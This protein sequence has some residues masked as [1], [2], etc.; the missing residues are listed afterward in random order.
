MIYKKEI[1][2]RVNEIFLKSEPVMKRFMQI[3]ENNIRK[4]LDNENI[5]YR[6]RK[7]RFRFFIEA[8]ETEKV[9]NILINI[10]GIYSISECFVIETNEIEKIKEFLKQ[11]FYDYVKE[12]ESF[13]IRAK[14]DGKQIYNSKE[15]E[16][17]LGKLIDRKVNLTKP[18]KTIFVE[19]SESET[20]FYTK[21][22][23]GIGGLPVGSSGKVLCLISGGIDSPV[24]CYMLMKRGCSIELIHFHSFP[25]VSRK[26]IDKVIRITRELT[27]FQ[28]KIKIHF[29]PFIEYQLKVK[30]SAK[31]NLRVMLY[32]RGMF[33]IAE[34]IAK[35]NKIK[36]LATGESIAQV[37]SQTLD[38]LEVSSKAIEM[39][40]L[41]P[42]IGLDK[43]E[44]INIAK[45]IN[46][47][48]IS[49]EPHEDCCTIFL[50][51]KSSAK[52]TIEEIEKIEKKIKVDSIVKKIIKKEKIEDI[53]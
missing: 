30:T 47:Y 34:N 29:I 7:K 13:A 10:P 24:A 18:D 16:K 27:K 36:F 33:K 2:V 51:K 39:E 21:V 40:I 9:K 42:L 38:N 11:Q 19:V 8:Q 45:K 20:L 1:L 4:M 32:R 44:I 52:T 12:N 14:T 5:S 43:E 31:E 15:I 17:E 3:L 28:P 37:S 22:E 35:K 50:P 46:T 53:N 26:S 48:E 41:R 25:F 49:I 23:K 6:I